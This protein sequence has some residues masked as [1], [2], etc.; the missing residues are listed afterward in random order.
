MQR[1]GLNLL[2][3]SFGLP[4]FSVAEVVAKEQTI[5]IASVVLPVNGTLQEPGVATDPAE[6][7]GGESIEQECKTGVGGNGFGNVCAGTDGRVEE[8]KVVAF[9]GV[10][11]SGRRDVV[12]LDGNEALAASYG[13]PE[14]F[15]ES[16]L[17]SRLH[18]LTPELSEGFFADV[19]V[20]V[21]G[22][23]DRAALRA[24]AAIKKV[25]LEALGIAILSANG[26]NNLDRPTAIF[27]TLEIPVYV[28]WDCDQSKNKIDGEQANRALQRLLGV[29][30]S[31]VVSAATLITDIFACFENKLE[32]V[33]E[34]EIGAGALV[35]AIDSAMKHFSVERKEDAMKAPALMEYALSQLAGNGLMSP[36]LEAIL[37]RVQALKT[38]SLKA[39]E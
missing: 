29:P 39:P 21:E 32:V 7:G 9:E 5:L 3:E 30:N 12:D 16:G 27:K 38:T 37:D 18:I 2:I 34:Q 22:E 23:S 25:D 33:L 24:V 11:D 20:L 15:T 4:E 36:S 1:G 26:K 8:D 17:R 6:I 35:A 13:L 14:F 28:I 31:E 19:V 10:L